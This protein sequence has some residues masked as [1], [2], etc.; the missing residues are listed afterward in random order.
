[1]PALVAG[2]RSFP[3][4]SDETALHSIPPGRMITEKILA[5]FDG[6]RNSRLVT[7]I[8]D[9]LA[10]KM[11]LNYAFSLRQTGRLSVVSF[12]LPFPSVGLPGYQS[13]WKRP[14]VGATFFDASGGRAL[15]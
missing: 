2:P 1:M 13:M 11:N 6:H 14:V 7:I 9:L 12:S 4:A 5:A 15:F 10:M 3:S 8:E